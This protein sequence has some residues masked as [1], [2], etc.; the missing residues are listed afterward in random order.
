MVPIAAA[1][2]LLFGYYWRVIGPA[3]YFFFY[4]LPLATLYQAQVRL[5]SASEHSFKTGY[6]V[7]SRGR[8]LSQSANANFLEWLIIGPLCSNY[9]FKHHQLPIAPYYN[10]P[11]VR[12]ILERKGIQ[13]PLG[14][15]YI[16]Y[17][18][19]RWREERELALAA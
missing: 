3:Y 11:V 6:N 13:V 15:G 4:F 1:Q 19:Q 10:L 12:D 2:A 9:H 5:R 18:A 7:P 16:G 8:W 17:L 14:T